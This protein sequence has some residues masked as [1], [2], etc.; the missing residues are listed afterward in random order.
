MTT[1]TDW[2]DAAA[3]RADAATSGPWEMHGDSVYTVLVPATSTTARRPAQRVAEVWTTDDDTVAIA[4]ARTDLPAAIAGLRA[5]L[6]LADQIEAEAPKPM[7][8]G[9][10]AEQLRNTVATALGVEP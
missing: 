3:A 10:L 2:L 7:V 5:V 6:T 4:A 8:G 9:F 1:L